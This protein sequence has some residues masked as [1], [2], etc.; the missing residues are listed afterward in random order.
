MEKVAINET[1]RDIILKNTDFPNDRDKHIVSHLLSG[2]KYR[3]CVWDGISLNENTVSQTK[4]RLIPYIITER[5]GVF[6]NTDICP[7]WLVGVSVQVEMIEKSVHDSIIESIREEYEQ[8]LNSSY[9]QGVNSSAERI[10]AIKAEYDRKI[11]E[12]TTKKEQESKDFENTSQAIKREYEEKIKALKEQFRA[13]SKDLIS[14]AREKTAKEYTDM[15]SKQVISLTEKNNALQIAFDKSKR[16]YQEITK[17]LSELGLESSRLESDKTKLVSEKKEL[18]NKISELSSILEAM[19]PKIDRGFILQSVVSVGWLLGLVALSV[20]S[21][22]NMMIYFNAGSYWIVAIIL[23]VFI[24]FMLWATNI[25]R[26]AGSLDDADSEYQSSE[27]AL[28]IFIFRAFA[29]SLGG[30]YIA[31][32]AKE[33]EQSGGLYA[34]MSTKFTDI[35]ELYFG[36]EV[37]GVG[38]VVTAII[39]GGFVAY[40]E[41]KALPLAIRHAY[42]LFIKSG[43]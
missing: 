28:A 42:Q 15:F 1:F 24:E 13:D 23:G 6:I 2:G 3:N 40:M 19:R 37:G 35:N 41:Y 39:I 16:E 22:E 43:N 34:N 5:S 27:L 8:K 38:M 32:N 20:F 17:F 4:K 29:N 12:I 9:H 11:S 36:W 21:V 7:S 31:T 18:E 33:F 14:D 26:F 25:T 30:Y 10:N